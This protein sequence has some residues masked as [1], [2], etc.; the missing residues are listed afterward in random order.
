MTVCIPVI[1]FSLEEKLKISEWLSWTFRNWLRNPKTGVLSLKGR[2]SRHDVILAFVSV[3]NTSS[4]RSK[5]CS[6]V[7]KMANCVAGPIHLVITRRGN[8]T[9]VFV[10]AVSGFMKQW[11]HRRKDKI[12]R[13]TTLQATAD[14]SRCW[15]CYVVT[16]SSDA[17]WTYHRLPENA[18]WRPEGLWFDISW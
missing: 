12:A 6:E 10:G 3:A 16:I 18:G 15:A 13:L 5:D 11:R 7:K 8:F 4:L 9:H 14:G 2:P 17:W 1:F